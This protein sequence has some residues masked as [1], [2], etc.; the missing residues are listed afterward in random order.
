MGLSLRVN[1]SVSVALTRAVFRCCE[2][3]MVSTNS[4]KRSLSFFSSL[5]IGVVDLFIAGSDER[6]SGHALPL[7]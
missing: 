1:H 6:N 5:L 4:T 7:Q 2:R 3:G